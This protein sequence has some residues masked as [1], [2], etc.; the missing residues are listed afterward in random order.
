[1]LLT[2]RR[3]PLDVCLVIFL[4]FEWGGL[5]KATLPFY[6]QRSCVI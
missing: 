3:L 2:S 4:A 1:M 6:E 5:P